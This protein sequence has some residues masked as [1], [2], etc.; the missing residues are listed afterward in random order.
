MIHT[1]LIPSINQK[2]AIKLTKIQKLNRPQRPVNVCVYVC[3]CTFV[4]VHLSHPPKSRW[5]SWVSVCMSDMMTDPVGG[6]VPAWQ[7]SRLRCQPSFSF[8][9]FFFYLFLLFPCFPSCRPRQVKTSKFHTGWNHDSVINHCVCVPICQN[10]SVV[11]FH[12]HL[13]QEL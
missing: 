7:S 8:T 4:S 6:R 11:T 13:S 10:W 1:H 3:N 12:F 9:P 2:I 5:L